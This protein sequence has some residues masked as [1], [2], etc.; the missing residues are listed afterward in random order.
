MNNPL[1]LGGI[2]YE[3]FFRD[4]WQ[5]RPLLV[6][7][8][9]PG[10]DGLIDPEALFRLSS[11]EDVVSRLVYQ[12]NQ[13]WQLQ[14]G[15]FKRKVFQS[16]QLGAT[17]TLLVQELNH[18]LRSAEIFLQ[19]F[20]FIPHAR[21]DDLMVS[22]APPGGGVG[23]H[24]DSYDVFLIQGMGRRLWQIGAQSDLALIDGLPLKIL[25]HFIP[26][27]EWILSP[28]DLLY[29]P[30]KY[31]HNGIA[32]DECMTYSV[33]FRAPS[34]QEMATQFLVYLQ[35]RI[36][37]PGQYKDPDLAFQAHPGEIKE[38][39]VEQ[40]AAMIKRIKWEQADIADFIGRY[41]TEPKA[42]VFFRLPRRPLSMATFCKQVM[43]C[44]LR[45][46]PQSQ[47]VFYR[48][49]YY[50]NG[51]PFDLPVTG[52]LK[53]M[54]DKRKISASEMTE[55]LIPL[56]YQGYLDGYFLIDKE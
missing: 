14:H 29:L 49:R 38:A 3:T 48:E 56:F 20:D 21:L 44:G 30:P 18:H 5:K 23:P 54:A 51:E 39:M 2:D 31:A 43:S 46:A 45:L 47:M 40:I 16:P 4:Y 25:R 55:A 26:E 53:T 41:I 24:F 17:W 42:H 37:L 35:D 33:G 13:I 22:Y 11:S 52:I 34:A 9:L 1:L 50:L 36:D 32:V 7:N 8:A 27:D 19:K 15:P 6:R 10:F 12:K 28:G